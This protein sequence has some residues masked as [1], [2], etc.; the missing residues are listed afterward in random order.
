M[1]T[2]PRLVSALGRALKLRRTDRQW[3]R[4]TLSRE[5]GVS[6]ATICRIELDGHGPSLRVLE[7]LAQALETSTSELLEVS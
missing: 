3:S 5:S 1:T 4:Q 6:Y 2:P 7:S